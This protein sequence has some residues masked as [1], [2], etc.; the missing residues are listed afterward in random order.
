MPPQPKQ[1]FEL[2]MDDGAVIRVRQHGNAKGPRVVMSHGNGF[3]MDGYYP[4]W[5]LLEER[6]EVVLFDLRSHGHNP[7][8]GPHGHSISAF[9]DDID[10]VLDELPKRWG[11]K[12]TIGAFH[13][14]SAVSNLDL[15]VTRGWRWD[16]LVVFDPPLA[17]GDGHPFQAAALD[18][19]ERL[20]SWA[21]RRPDR[22]QGPEELADMLSGAKTHYRWVPGAHLGMARAVLRPDEAA[23]DWMLR[24]PRRMESAIYACNMDT[25]VWPRLGEIPGPLKFVGADPEPDDHLWPSVANRAIGEA[26]DHAYEC[27]PDTNHLLQVEH[28]D[29]C[30]AAMESFLAE[31]GINA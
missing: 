11:Q 5:R 10:R 30:F 27:I 17:P 13:S 20:A 22:F 3:A 23:D 12:T 21:L 6:Y 15:A 19:E 26:F 29:L 28:P 8:H 4:M 16:A 14:V 9:V 7:F 2:T 24:C 25:T 18:G 1:A 31:N